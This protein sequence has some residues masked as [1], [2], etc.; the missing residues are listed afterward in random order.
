[1]VNETV[2]ENG[3]VTTIFLATFQCGITIA[4]R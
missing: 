3:T 1:M 2:M 4:Y